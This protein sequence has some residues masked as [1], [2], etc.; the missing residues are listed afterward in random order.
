MGPLSGPA[1][2]GSDLSG[3]R[4]LITGGNGFLG[5]HLCERLVACGAVVG[6]LSRGKGLLEGL[7]VARRVA[8]LQCD[9]AD[10]ERSIREIQGFAPQVLVHLASHPDGREDLR[11]AEAAIRLNTL[12]TLHALEGF[13]LAG[14]GLFVYGDSTKVYGNCEVPYRETTPPSP[15]SS[16]A[17]A[18][19]AGWQLCELY[20][21]LHS[22]LVCAV[23]PTLVY[24]ARQR[25]NLFSYVADR[26]RRGDPEIRLD[27]GEQTRDP[28]Y[29]DDAI[30]AY[31]ATLR[32]GARVVGRTINI[33]GGREYTVAE[34]AG[35]VVR[36]L[37]G[38]QRVV[39]VPGQARPTEIWR[40][41]C[42][43]REAR[44]LIG[45]Q[46]RTDLESGL[47]ATLGVDEV[48]AAALAC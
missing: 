8:F 13:R 3:R 26:V 38:G 36:I 44:E 45:W 28:L 11:Q 23:R 20:A 19:L 2:P 42:D 18:K 22:V 15:T 16:Y 40:S 37:G 25:W 39:C 5:S 17:I 43:G 7:P 48:R 32:S 24:G 41:W 31:V 1:A 4:V 14:G 27:G 46:P 9:L 21:R 33:G 10:G 29:V 30:D 12:A 47:R 35:L 6:S 34:L